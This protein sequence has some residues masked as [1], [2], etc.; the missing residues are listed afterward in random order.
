MDTYRVNCAVLCPIV[1]HL[2]GNGLG[3]VDRQLHRLGSAGVKGE[4][5]IYEPDLIP[6]KVRRSPAHGLGLSVTGKDKGRQ[7][8]QTPAR[9][10][11]HRLAVS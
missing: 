3:R 5:V 7:D 4:P 10:E 2:T 6:I 11:G 9:V 8:R 1:Q